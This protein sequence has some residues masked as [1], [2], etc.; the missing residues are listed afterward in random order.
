[1]K[2]P[3]KTFLD[4]RGAKAVDPKPLAKYVATMN[5]TVIPEILRDVRSRE[6]LAAELRY[7]RTASSR[8]Q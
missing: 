3:Q 7:S 5:E 8:G 6:Q 2:N 1:M 4:S